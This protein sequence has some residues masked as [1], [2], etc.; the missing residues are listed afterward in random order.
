MFSFMVLTK[1]INMDNL[2]KAE[3][4]FSFKFASGSDTFIS[5]FSFFNNLSITCG[6]NSMKF[7]LYDKYLSKDKESLINSYFSDKFV[8]EIDGIS[9]EDKQSHLFIDQIAGREKVM[10]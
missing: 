1:D 6:R 9:V 4:H 2:K 8:G 10:Y 5:G 7:A 3:E